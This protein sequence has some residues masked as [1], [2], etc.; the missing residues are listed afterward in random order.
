MK[1]KTGIFGVIEGHNRDDLAQKYFKILE[2]ESVKYKIGLCVKN[3]DKRWLPHFEE[4]IV[5]E[6]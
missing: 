3:E 2:E 1:M 6:E 5:S 4:F